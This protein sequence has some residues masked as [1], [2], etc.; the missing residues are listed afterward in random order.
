MTL[1]GQ[2][3]K[4][5]I[6]EVAGI[7][8]SGCAAA[9]ATQSSGGV[10]NRSLV[11]MGEVAWDNCQC[12]QL[13]L[14]ITRIYLSQTFPQDASRQQTRCPT[15]Y[16]V[17]D[18]SLSIVRCVPGPDLNGNPPDA[19]ALTTA[20]GIELQ[21]AFVT[22]GMT[23]CILMS[24]YSSTPYGIMEY[25]MLDQTSLG[26]LGSCAGTALNFKIGFNRTGICCG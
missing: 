16:V 20:A 9:L 15:G 10:V 1:N 23:E 13:A 14:T 21:D 12:G 2:Y 3:T 5:A 7:I 19:A 4:T 26:P 24:L 17:A 6:L 11:T 18:C 8:V 22:W 25:V